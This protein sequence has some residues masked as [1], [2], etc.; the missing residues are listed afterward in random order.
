[1]EEKI[2]ELEARVAFLEAELEMSYEEEQFR[3][4]IQSIFPDGADIESRDGAYGYFAR[5]T[6][7]NGDEVQMA[8]DRLENTDYGHAV[9]ETGEGLG[10]EVWSEARV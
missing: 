2:A 7:I 1:M 8:I 6:D 4:R 3:R 10:M 9:T 5:V